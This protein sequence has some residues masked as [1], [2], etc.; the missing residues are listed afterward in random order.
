MAW[1]EAL[2]ALAEHFRQKSTAFYTF[3]NKTSTRGITEVFICRG[4]PHYKMSGDGVV[5]S[6]RNANEDERIFVFEGPSREG[7]WVWYPNSLVLLRRDSTDLPQNIAHEE[8]FGIGN[9]VL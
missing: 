8:L 9:A 7:D 6:L 2:N 5:I 4:L 3:V 1:M